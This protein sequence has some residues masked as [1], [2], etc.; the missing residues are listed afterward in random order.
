MKRSNECLTDT[1]TRFSQHRLHCYDLC[2]SCAPIIQ[3]HCGKGLAKN[4]EEAKT[5]P[6]FTK[7]HKS[8]REL[9]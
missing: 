5:I 9:V 4:N 7:S 1:I 8:V 3:L 6:C 2:K